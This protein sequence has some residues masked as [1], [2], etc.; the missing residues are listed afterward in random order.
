MSRTGWTVTAAALLCVVS[1]GA[2]LSRRHLLGAE[3]NGPQGT[4]PWR[5]TL[6]VEGEM[7]A[8]HT[9][10]KTLPPL[11][12][13]QQHIYDEH[14]ES[15]ELS[16][17][18]V[19]V[20]A[21]GRRDVE[22]QRLSTSGEQ[23]FQL[24]YSF[25]CALGLWPPT[26]AMER[27]TDNVDAPPADRPVLR[28]A[29]QGRGTYL[30]PSHRVQSEH[31]DVQHLARGLAPQDLTP[32]DQ[33]RALF[34]HVRRM[35]TKEGP[36]T[37][38]ALACVRA[39]GGGSAGK[40]R[41]LV[42]LC[43]SR[44]IPA[45]LAAG[46]ILN[47]DPTQGLHY[48]VEAWIN[49]YWLPMCPARGHFG[50]QTFPRNYL[51]FN[52][53]EE[54]VVRG[55]ESTSQATFTVEKLD[56]TSAGD[57]GAPAF[58][59]KLSLYRLRPREQ[60]VVRF[61]LLLPLAAL[62]VCLFRTVIGLPTFGT[63]AP[64]LMGMAFLDLKVLPWGMLIFL[65]MVLAGWLLRRLLDRLHLLQVPRVSALLTLLVVLLVAGIWAGSHLGLLATIDDTLLPLVILTHL[66]ERFWTV[67]TEDGTAA[68]FKTL[69]GTFV[70]A[71]TVSVALSPQDVGTWML[72]YPETT[73]VVLACQLL[74]GRYTGYRLSELYRFDELLI[75]EGPA[76][77][78]TGPV[79][80]GVPSP[81]GPVGETDELAP[82]VADAAGPGH[83]GD[84][85]PQ[86]HLYPGSEPAGAAAAGGRQEADAR[87]VPADRRPHA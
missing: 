18:E 76:Q 48:W 81:F 21:T 38:S 51:V 61:L 40:S 30:K 84:E 13:R 70:V 6:Q 33:L 78:G 19:Q 72:R 24:T 35:P 2:L 11:D 86:R 17:R 77:K 7:P 16:H 49:N 85:P 5:V 8:D 41:L 9:G 56:Q 58:W 4:S 64:A 26:P 60:R 52:L 44:G 37:Q 23:P 12:F 27:L 83:P 67:E 54:D 63:F 43:R 71:V 3:I 10:L 47:G 20:K 45:R 34:D 74:L 28:R 57:A 59:K 14:F 15:E 32:A 87:L 82:K 69:A 39:G 1:L 65:A 25:Q 73:G 75:E 62:I 66:V 29:P 31:R 50:A 68:S 46:L 79:I 53:G 80:L 42:A 55:Q 22:W 36:A